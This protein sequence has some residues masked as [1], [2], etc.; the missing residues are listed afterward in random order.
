MITAYEAAVRLA[1]LGHVQEKRWAGI[2][3]RAEPG[4]TFRYLGTFLIHRPHW[5]G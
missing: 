3:L 4:D 5:G 2:R 1:R